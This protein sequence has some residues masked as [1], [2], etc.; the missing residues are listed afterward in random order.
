M[1]QRLPDD[2]PWASDTVVMA[3]AG[4]WESK[5]GDAERVA[6]PR[7]SRGPGKSATDADAAPSASGNPHPV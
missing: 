6:E 1:H 2:P 5:Q 7:T 4:L 3:N